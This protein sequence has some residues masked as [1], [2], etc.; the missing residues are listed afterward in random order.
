MTGPPPAKHATDAKRWDLP[1]EDEGRHFNAR[2][3][4]L[5]RVAT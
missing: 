4:N 5:E 2:A 3:E 1:A